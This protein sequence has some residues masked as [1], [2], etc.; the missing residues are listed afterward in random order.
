MPIAVT[1][2]DDTI[3]HDDVLGIQRHVSNVLAAYTMEELLRNPPTIKFAIAGPVPTIVIVHD[4]DDD[5]D[6]DHI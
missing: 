1:I 2:N 5:D 6:D 3:V 4:D